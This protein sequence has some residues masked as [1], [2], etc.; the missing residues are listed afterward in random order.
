VKKKDKPAPVGETQCLGR[1]SMLEKRSE[2]RK[3]KKKKEA[4]QT[5]SMRKRRE[6]RKLLEKAPWGKI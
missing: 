1:V 3:N 4:P 6:R 5:N 2:E